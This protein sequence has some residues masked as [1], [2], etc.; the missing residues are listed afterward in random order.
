MILPNVKKASLFAK[1]MY[2]DGKL[3]TC[4]ELEETK[5][6]SINQQISRS[7][8]LTGTGLGEVTG[9]RELQ[10]IHDENINQ[11]KSMDEK[12]ILAEK[13]KLLNTLGKKEKYFYYLKI[14]MFYVDPKLIAFIRKRNK[15][16]VEKEVIQI[17]DKSNVQ[18]NMDIDNQINLPIE[19]DSR[20]VNMNNIENE[21][22]EWM[23]DLP[24]PSAQRTVDESVRKKFSFS[25]I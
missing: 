18:K 6:S 8:L 14:F 13:E 10:R 17:N 3:K 19:T 4:K 9:E 12:E 20:W 16:E 7:S 11:L 24:K 1:Q 25:L 21:K 22:L 2:R 15:N 23:K 5:N